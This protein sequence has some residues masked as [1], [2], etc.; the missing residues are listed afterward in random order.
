MDSQVITQAARRRY[1]AFAAAY[2][3]LDAGPTDAGLRAHYAQRLRALTARL[4][5]PLTVLDLG[6]GTGRYFHCLTQVER[7]VGVDVSPQMLAQARQ[8]HRAPEIAARRIE[9]ICGNFLDQHFPPG[10]FDLIYAIGVLGEYAPLTPAL[11]RRLWQWLKPGG[12]LFFTVV[13]AASKPRPRSL[14]R[15]LASLVLPLLP[16]AAR[17]RLQQERLWRSLYLSD[18][19]LRAFLQDSPLAQATITRHAAAAGDRWQGAHFN[20][21]ITKG[22]ED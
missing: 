18:A 10:T 15:R 4:T 12:V 6:C 16:A 2:R 14:K 21:E 11:C 13:D 1:D 7:L 22:A 3:Q 19:Q 9:L 5:P 20:C 17:E 8:P